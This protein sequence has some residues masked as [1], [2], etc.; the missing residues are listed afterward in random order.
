MPQTGGLQLPHSKPQRCIRQIEACQGAGA[1]EGCEKN[2]PMQPNC[3]TNINHQKDPLPST[4]WRPQRARRK[5][6]PGARVLEPPGKT[7]RSRPACHA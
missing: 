6:W 7:D 5:P 3:R 4:A 2:A 1:G